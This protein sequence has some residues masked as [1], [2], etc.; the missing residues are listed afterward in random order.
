ME[1]HSR[2]WNPARH[3]T[4]HYLILLLVCYILL[5]IYFCCLFA[6]LHFVSRC[7]FCSQ[8]L[9]VG[10]AVVLVVLEIDDLFDRPAERI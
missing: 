4:S 3:K 10:S 8:F 9:S 1:R 6:F 7:L 2:A 5:F